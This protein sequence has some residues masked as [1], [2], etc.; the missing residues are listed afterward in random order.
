ME[1]RVLTEKQKLLIASLPEEILDGFYLTGGTALSAFY[2]EHRLSM[3][4]DFFTDKK[5]GIPPVEYLRAMLREVPYLEAVHF[6]RL[7]DRRIFKLTFSDGD[8]LNVEFTLYPFKGLGQRKKIGRLWVDSPLD[9]ATGKL[10]AMTDRFDPKD[11]VD[12]YF[13]LRDFEWTLNEL[14]E[15]AA[16][17]FEVKGL[18]YTVP[19]RL[20]LVRRIE[21]DDLP[22]ML[23]DLD[24]EEMKKYLISKASALAGA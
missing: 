20:L 8:I 6:Q 10:F 5:K 19:E 1:N 15:K 22:I 23:K 13:I 24:I 7:F 2:I 14:L 17:R 4:M 3:D 16:F 11:F 9:I 12:L 18:Q 21:A